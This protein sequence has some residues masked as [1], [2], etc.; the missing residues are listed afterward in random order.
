M[1][2]SRRSFVK[3][4]S[5]SLAAL[6]LEPF[7]IGLL[8]K[9]LASPTGPKVI[10]LHGSSCTG[11]SVSF[12]NRISESAPQTVT[13][14]LT[15][16]VDLIYHPTIMALAGDPASAVLARLYSEG[17][18]V[19]V[20]EGGVPTAF[21]GNACIAYT[22]NGREVTFMEAVTKLSSRSIANVCIGT[23]ASFGGIPAAGSNPTKV[24]SVG[25][26][27]GRPTINISGCPA[28]PDWAVW[29]IVQLI[30]GNPIELDS[31]RR[32]VALY[33]R[34]LAG[35]PCESTIHNKCPR[36]V[37]IHPEAPPAATDFGQ[38]GRCLADLGCRGPTTKARCDRC[39]NG[40][41]GQGSW[42]IGVNA[43]CHGCTERTFPGPQSFYEPF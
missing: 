17:N 8:R 31:D 19:F 22:L 2:V 35:L 30:L 4:C 26:L 3:Y 29:A 37:E 12:L 5:V 9:A 41:A 18:Y 33:N 23:C 40:I 7:D 36:N 11:C 43:P 21:N 38:D 13:D 16:A 6:G 42:C 39:W 27:T 14:V 32:P 28:N 10:W 25:A 24:V 15:G 20:A 1:H 34:D